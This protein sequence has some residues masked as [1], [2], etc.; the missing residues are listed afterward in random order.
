MKELV[1]IPLSRI[2]RLAVVVTDCKM[3][4]DQVKA[5]TGADYILNGGMWNADGTPCRGLKVDGGL[6]S[7]EPWAIP[8]PSS[9]T[10]GPALKFTSAPSRIRWS[11]WPGRS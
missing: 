1:S 10:A 2:S 9:L 3:G 5:M 11:G 7:A 6:L 8:S 4:L